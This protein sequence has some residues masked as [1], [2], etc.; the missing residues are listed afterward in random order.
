MHALTRSAGEKIMGFAIWTRLN[1]ILAVLLVG[2]LEAPAAQ[3]AKP[4]I[5]PEA[6]IKK[7]ETVIRT[8]L[9]K[10][11]AGAKDRPG[12]RTLAV[13]L[14]SQVDGAKD[15]AEK[16]VLLRDAIE[17]A[18]GGMDFPFAIKTIG[19]LS[20]I[21]DVNPD[22][23]TTAMIAKAK[24]GSL[25]LE[26]ATFL[27]ESC[28]MVWE[29]QM[30]LEK[31]DLAHKWAKEAEPIAKLAKDQVLLRSTA[32]M[33]T[34]AL[35]AKKAMERSV[36][37]AG[38]NDADFNLAA[39]TYLCFFRGDWEKGL[40]ALAA[41]SN[42]TLQDLAKKEAQAATDTEAQADLSLAWAALAEKE[43]DA[44]AKRRYYARARHWREVALK[45]LTGLAKTKA[46]K[47]LFPSVTL[48]KATV[49]PKGD[50]AKLL[51]EALDERPG[52]PVMIDGYL[53]QD[54]GVP[55]G[56]TLTVEYSVDNQKRR[57]V[58]NPGESMFVPPLSMP[59]PASFRFTLVAAYYG[60]GW[61]MVDVTDNARRN[62]KDPFSPLSGGIAAADTTPFRTKTLVVVAEI[63]GRRIVRTLREGEVSATLMR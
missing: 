35:D 44:G 42:P 30:Q 50:G 25:S 59:G 36:A 11:Y 43:K 22:E 19:A 58:G 53:A 63:Y 32:E 8:A 17:Y 52:A 41:G 28:L 1:G 4:P 6:E 13:K 62:Y 9:A 26:D 45:G 37:A 10:E 24:K 40:P 38:A 33:A 54:A 60:S 57:D 14:A 55:A 12:K 2:G 48:I 56:A 16:Y 3:N 29:R 21:F 49:S 34:E 5:P 18:A 31:Y 15:P 20:G 46:T 27:A 7:A 51:Q 47:K 39:G 23:L 61:K